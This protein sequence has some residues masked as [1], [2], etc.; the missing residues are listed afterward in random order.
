MADLLDKKLRGFH[1]IDASAGTGKTYTITA[2][3]VRLLLE[4]RLTIQEILVVTY[5]EAAAT[6]LRV[7]IR[8][9]LVAARACFS[10]HGCHEHFLANLY[11]KLSDHDQTCRDLACALNDFDEAAIYTIHGFCQRMLKEN[12]LESATLF[13][14]ELVADLSDIHWQVVC[15]YW[16]QNTQGKGLLFL[17]YLNERLSPEKLQQLVGYEFGGPYLGFVNGDDPKWL[18][19]DKPDNSPLAR[20]RPDIDEAQEKLP[21]FRFGDVEPIATPKGRTLHSVRVPDTAGKK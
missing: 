8:E 18:V 3:V 19:Q 16:R 13:D 11:D 21:R 2:L 4:E 9:M 17:H 15:D 7:R 12:G 1:L 6:D 5:T 10:G 14:V 20:S